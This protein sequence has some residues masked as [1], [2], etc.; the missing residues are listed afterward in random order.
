MKQQKVTKLMVL[1]FV[2]FGAG[3]MARQFA[4]QLIGFATNELTIRFVCAV[5]LGIISHWLYDLLKRAKNHQ[6]PPINK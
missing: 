4:P 2:N 1:S 5:S 6:E 3:A